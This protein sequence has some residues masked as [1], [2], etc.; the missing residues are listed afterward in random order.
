DREFATPQAVDLAGILVDAG[1]RYAEFGKACAGDEAHIPCPNHC[2]AHGCALRGCRDDR[3]SPERAITG[4]IP[5]PRAAASRRTHPLG[6]TR[7]GLPV[8]PSFGQR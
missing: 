5:P 6:K 8:V 7:S 1:D 3:R 2:Y 4:V